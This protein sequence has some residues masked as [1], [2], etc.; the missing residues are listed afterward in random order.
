MSKI[1]FTIHSLVDVEVDE[2]TLPYIQIN[3]SNTSNNPT[4][5]TTNNPTNNEINNQSQNTSLG[6]KTKVGYLFQEN[7]I[8]IFNIKNKIEKLI[9]N[10]KVFMKGKDFLTS[11]DGIGLIGMLKG[12][13]EEHCTCHLFDNGDEDLPFGEILYSWEIINSESNESFQ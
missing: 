10:I 9:F 5:N 8:L 2:G 11:Y 13:G 4:N 3:L 7:N 6:K 12:K 1:K